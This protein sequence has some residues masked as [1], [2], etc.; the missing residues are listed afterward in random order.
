MSNKNANIGEVFLDPY[1]SQKFP[2][3][4]TV[5]QAAELAS[6]PKKT[7]YIWSSDGLLEGC[8]N[9]F[10]KRLRIFRDRFVQL[11]MNPQGDHT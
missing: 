10:G 9:R 8:A 7:I 6:V 11:L 2:P 5:D 1:W 3:I 4:L